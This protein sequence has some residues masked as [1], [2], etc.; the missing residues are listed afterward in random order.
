MNPLIIAQL[1]DV[2]LQL[3]A[4]VPALVARFK[5]TRDEL[6]KMHAEGR[7]LQDADWDAVHKSMNESVDA[8]LAA[9]HKEKP[10]V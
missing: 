5:A 3:V 1:L 8:I 7:S 4:E 10:V 9:A 6:V 2:I